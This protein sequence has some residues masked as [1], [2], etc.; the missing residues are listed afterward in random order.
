MGLLDMV[1]DKHYGK[2]SKKKA[3][4]KAGSMKLHKSRNQ[5]VSKPKIGRGNKGGRKR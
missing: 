4:G 2:P 3:S 5:H 1:Y